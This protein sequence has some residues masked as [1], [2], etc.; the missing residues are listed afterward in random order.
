MRRCGRSRS[1]PASDALLTERASVQGAPHGM[2][3]ISGGT[4]RMGSDKHYPEEVPAH[5]AKVDG[6]WIDRTPV[7]NSEFRRFV[8]RSGARHPE[9]ARAS[10]SATQSP[11]I[12]G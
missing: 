7:T 12:G 1:T 9:H 11:T 2:V 8:N 5:R 4:F 3:R 6:F 10:V